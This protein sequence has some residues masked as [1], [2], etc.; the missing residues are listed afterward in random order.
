M[1]QVPPEHFSL[2]PMILL[3]LVIFPPSD[4]IGKDQDWD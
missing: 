1:L 2:L 3:L 4:I